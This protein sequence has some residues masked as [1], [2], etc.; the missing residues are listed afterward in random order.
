MFE[1]PAGRIE[2]S[3]ELTQP[4]IDNP[5]HRRRCAVRWPGIV[6]GASSEIIGPALTG[7]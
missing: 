4:A 6:I 5:R 3:A 1:L 2:C 7:R